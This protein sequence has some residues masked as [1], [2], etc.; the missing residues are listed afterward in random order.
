MRVTGKT[1]VIKVYLPAIRSRMSAFLQKKVRIEYTIR[2]RDTGSIIKAIIAAVPLFS[3]VKASNA[4]A[5]DDNMTEICNYMMKLRSLAK[6]NLGS[7]FC[8][9]ILSSRSTWVAH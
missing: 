6:N 7:D 9:R 8:P 4:V 5:I 3:L 2:R 1:Q